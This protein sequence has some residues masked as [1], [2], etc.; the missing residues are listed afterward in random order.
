MAMET[1]DTQLIT[2]FTDRM[3]VKAQQK[4]SRLQEAAMVLPIKGDRFA[5]DGLGD[6]EARE[7]TGRFNKSE[8]DDIEFFRRKISRRRF[9]V[10]L[11]VDD[12]DVEA[13]LTNPNSQLAAACTRAMERVKDR[14]I[15]EAALADVQTGRDFETTVTAAADGVL[16][17]DATGGLTLPKLLEVD[18]NWIDGEVGNDEDLK[19][20]FCISGDEHTT[21]MQISQLTSGDYRR[22][23]PLDG[24]GRMQMAAGFKLVKFGASARKP[25]LAVSGG[26]RS[27]VAMVKDAVALGIAR[28]V[29]VTVK[30]RPDYVDTKQIQVTGIFGAVRT[31]GKLVQEVTTT[32]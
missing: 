31:E 16:T 32:D 25:V 26:E 24:D 13:M 21:L 11:F 12:M 8:V 10:T 3:H 20:Y 30:D 17:V 19:K 27:N 18:Q 28:G 5:Y 4:K 29:K 7:L 9:V 1:I 22:Q 15:I 2:Q 23:L 14:I 6:V